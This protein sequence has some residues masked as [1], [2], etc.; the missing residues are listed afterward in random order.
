[1]ESL[2][3]GQLSDRSGVAVSA[4]RYY[5][6]IGLLPIPGRVGGRR[7]YS[8]ETLQSLALIRLGQ[9]AGF[10]LAELRELRMSAGDG[11]GHPHW[12][13]LLGRKIESTAAEI[14]RLQRVQGLLTGALA[15]GCADIMTCAGRDTTRGQ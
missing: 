12:A 14:E 1:M 11:P 7:R 6:R 13:G 15:C 10:T 8:T 5:E 4:I 9:K 2:S 3:I